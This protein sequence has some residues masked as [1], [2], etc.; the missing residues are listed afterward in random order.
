MKNKMLITSLLAASVSMG[1][2]AET[3]TVNVD[4][5]KEAIPISITQKT[6]MVISA[7]RID[8]SVT[9]GLVICTSYGA[10]LPDKNYCSGPFN[11]GV[12]T[13]A[14]A[15]FAEVNYAF[16]S[17]LLV[18]GGLS[19]SLYNKTN[20]AAGALVNVD[21]TGNVDVEMRGELKV[22]D[23]SQVNTGSYQFDFNMTAVYN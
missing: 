1:A 20:S 2:S 7:V 23:P 14:G 11:N 15:P 16:D 18:N 9:D 22:D 12:Y 3:F 21:S 4:V 5:V 17:S 8:E 10:P 13:I 19:L 6:P